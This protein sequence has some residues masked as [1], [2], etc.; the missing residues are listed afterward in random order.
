MFINKFILSYIADV[1]VKGI[2]CNMAFLINQ[3]LH[4]VIRYVYQNFI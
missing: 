4:D 3:R 2:R 1:L